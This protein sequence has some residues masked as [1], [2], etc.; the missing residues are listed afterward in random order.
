MAAGGVHGA[1]AGFEEG[2]D[3]MMG[4][5]TVE[6]FEMEGAAGG[7]SEALEEFAG[8]AEAEGRGHVLGAVLGWD[9]AM[10]EGMQASPDEGGA[11]AEIDDGAG[12][13]FVHGQVGL[14]GEGIAGVETGAIAADA[15]FIAQGLEE[16]L[17]Q[18]DAAVLDGMV[19]IDLQVAFA[20]EG[21]VHGG[22]AGEEGEHVIEEGDPGVDTGVAATVD[23][24]VDT[25]SGFLG[26]PVNAGPSI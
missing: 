12:Q 20:A 2:F 19:G 18:G 7:I 1:G 5:L 6:E 22:M 23:E 3:D 26:D 11:T 21:Q 4:F 24:E 13:G 15:S 16:R 17:A 9:P 25:D 14:A 8:Q 10:G